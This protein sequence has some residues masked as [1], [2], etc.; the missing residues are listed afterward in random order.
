MHASSLC[1]QTVL[2]TRARGRLFPRGCR[3]AGRGKH[4]AQSCNQPFQLNKVARCE[5]SCLR[6]LQ[7]PH[8]LTDGLTA[9]GRERSGA[10]VRGSAGSGAPRLGVLLARHNA[11][12]GPWPRGSDWRPSAFT[13]PTRFEGGRT[14]TGF[15]QV[16]RLP[17]DS[18]STGGKPANLSGPRELAKGSQGGPGA[19]PALTRA[20]DT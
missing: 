8:R 12:L 14:S 11:G 3:S 9:P 2:A 13:E 5:R 1:W 10:Q 7:C 4:R 17:S 6:S 19:C 15:F 18:G 16:P 20:G